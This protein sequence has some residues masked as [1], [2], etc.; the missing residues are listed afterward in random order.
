MI[1]E[2][3]FMQMTHSNCR[4]QIF[5]RFKF[6]DASLSWWYQCWCC[7]AVSSTNSTLFL[8]HSS[9]PVIKQYSFTALFTIMQMTNVL[10]SL[11]FPSIL[12]FLSFPLNCDIQSIIAHRLAALDPRVLWF[13]C[14]LFCRR[15]RK[16]RQTWPHGKLDTIAQPGPDGS[17]LL[18]MTPSFW[19]THWA[20]ECAFLLRHQYPVNNDAHLLC[21]CQCH[22][23]LLSKTKFF[24]LKYSI[25]T[26]T[27]TRQLLH[28]QLT[29]ELCE[30]YCLQYVNV[31]LSLYLSSCPFSSTNIVLTDHKQIN[32]VKF[33]P[34]LYSIF[35]LL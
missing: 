13:V 1:D 27:V 21:A 6:V 17:L 12:H 4:L 35:A 10:L 32:V 34:S 22:I 18:M 23:N 20:S 29:W 7:S 2:C 5:N 3:W 19:C 9:R 28:W 16:G 11:S 31:H 30:L 14:K 15:M 25:C 8:E 24:I 33:N 26:G